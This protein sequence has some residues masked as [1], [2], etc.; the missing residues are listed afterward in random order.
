M[1]FDGVVRAAL[2]QIGYISPFVGLISVQEVKDPFFFTAP[3][4]ASLDHGV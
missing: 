4:G 1:V 3:S 2:Q